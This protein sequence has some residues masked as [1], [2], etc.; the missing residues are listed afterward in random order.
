MI[1]IVNGESAPCHFP[2]YY[3]EFP[4][5]HWEAKEKD[6]SLERQIV[7]EKV[8]SRGKGPIG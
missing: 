2:P 4:L 6:R 1:P 3:Q 5:P 7:A 8:S